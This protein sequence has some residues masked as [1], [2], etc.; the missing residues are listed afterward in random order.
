[1]FDKKK[2]IL[3]SAQWGSKYG[4]TNLNGKTS[5]SEV[6]KILEFAH[7]NGTN[8][9]DTANLYGEA[10]YTLGK[11]N[12]KEFKIITKTTQL[13]NHQI[14][15]EDIDHL[16]KEFYLSLKK[17]NLKRV[18][19][20]LIHRSEDIF[21]ENSNLIINQLNL[22]KNN[23]LVQKIG[24]SIY[25]FDCIDKIFDIFVPDLIQLPFNIFDQRLLE[26]NNL[27]KI[28]SKNIELH[29]RS[30]FLQGTLLTDPK[31][32]PK[33]FNQWRNLYQKWEDSCRKQNISKIEAS[34]MCAMN[35]KE[36]DGIVIGFENL[37]QIKECYNSRFSKILNFKHHD[38]NNVDLIDP[39]RWQ[40]E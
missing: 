39:R 24:I 2:I 13:N 22:F 14:T 27:Q 28:K 16:R 30:I 26:G 25:D 7:N 33:Y 18:Y 19:G 10:E 38:I 34:I 12:L 15:K 31:K 37:S 40:Y 17:L 36:I 5:I 29:A 35:I 9:I 32:L 4:V 1:M 20:L 3:G 6:R 23:G 11:L 21:K 8:A